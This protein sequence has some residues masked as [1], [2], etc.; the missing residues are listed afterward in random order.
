MSPYRRTMAPTWWLG[1][2]AYFLFMVRELS[3]VF[4]AAYL[5]L[6]LL[7]LHRLTI[8]R[9]AYEAYLQ[10]L[11]TPGMLVFHALALGFSLF[12][13]ITWFN[14]TPKVLVVHVGEERVPAKIVVG[15][16]YGAW[17]AVSAVIA[18]IVVRR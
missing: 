16:N 14:I 9:Q 11:A 1:N 12:H 10:F 6:F 18:W 13:A 8:S 4:V 2:R 15:V 17:I 5:V 7:L 3:S